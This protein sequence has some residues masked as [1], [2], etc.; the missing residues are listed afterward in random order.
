MKISNSRIAE[1]VRAFYRIFGIELWI[2]NDQQRGEKRRPLTAWVP[3]LAGRI[4]RRKL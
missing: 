4:P 3:S 1:S 2:G